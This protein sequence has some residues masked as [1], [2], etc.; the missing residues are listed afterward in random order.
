[1]TREQVEAALRASRADYTEIRLE[2]V[3]STRVVFRG[4]DLETA[5]VVLPELNVV[6]KG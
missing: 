3:E 1:M 4:P 2:R 5:D 6:T